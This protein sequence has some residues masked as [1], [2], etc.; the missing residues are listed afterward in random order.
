[1]VHSS[2]FPVLANIA[3]DLLAIP[4][5]TVAS[6]SAFSTGG[7]VLDEYCSRLSTRTVEAL[8]CT[9]DWLGG[10][11]TPLP[12][13]EDMEDLEIIERDDMNP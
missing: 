13:Q 2:R 11:P 9:K 4:V 10:S 7:R 3:R 8:I 5:S 1:M 6:E 12:T